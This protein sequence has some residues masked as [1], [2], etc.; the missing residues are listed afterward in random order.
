MS[1]TSDEVIVTLDVLPG[2]AEWFEH[3][4]FSEGLAVSVFRQEDGMAVLALSNL[5]VLSVQDG[6]VK[7]GRRPGD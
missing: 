3:Q 2:N 7:L 4:E 6:V 1:K 5:R